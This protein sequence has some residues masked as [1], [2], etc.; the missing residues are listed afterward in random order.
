MTTLASRGTCD[1]ILLSRLPREMHTAPGILQTLTSCGSRT[2]S[3]V[4]LS[5]RRC[6]SMTWSG[7]TSVMRVLA[8]A[9]R[10]APVFMTARE[11]EVRSPDHHERF[12]IGV[13]LGGGSERNRPLVGRV[14]NRKI[15]HARNCALVGELVQQV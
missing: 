14:P 10:S 15:G 9:R 13:E 11:T 3:S 7:S 4:T 5:P 8:S 2:S 12:V 6:M 1:S